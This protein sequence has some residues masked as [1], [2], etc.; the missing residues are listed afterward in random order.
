MLGRSDLDFLKGT[1]VPSE[2]GT[3]SLPVWIALVVVIFVI[4]AVSFARRRK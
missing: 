1:A 3:V 4:A 2:G